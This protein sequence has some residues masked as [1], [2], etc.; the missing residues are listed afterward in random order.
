MIKVDT[1]DHGMLAACQW[2]GTS[3]I[4]R[5]VFSFQQVA[6]RKICLSQAKSSQDY[7]LSASITPASRPSAKRRLNS[8]KF[9]TKSLIPEA[10]SL[11]ME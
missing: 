8:M 11:W 5:L 6:M 7:F 9:V 3:H 10:L 1:V 4:F 2:A